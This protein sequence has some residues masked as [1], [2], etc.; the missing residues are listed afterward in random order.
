MNKYTNIET[1][2]KIL[3]SDLDQGSDLD[4][5]DC[6]LEGLDLLLDLVEDAENLDDDV[7]EPPLPSKR[8]PPVKALA[9]LPSLQ[10]HLEVWGQRGDLGLNRE[11]GE[12]EEEAV[13][14]AQQREMKLRTGGIRS[15]KMRSQNNLCLNPNDLKAHSCYTNKYGDKKQQGGRKMS[16]KPVTMGD[17]LNYI[18]LVIYMGL[19]KVSRLVDN[20]SKSPLYWFEFPT[21]IMSENR[22]LAINRT[23]HE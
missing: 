4:N 5:E 23:L 21:S 22:F 18:S 2:N 20:W 7:W 12:A 1:L 9:P 14:A 13:E 3:E 17:M 8:P 11:V 10:V 16:W 15:L 19:V 6:S